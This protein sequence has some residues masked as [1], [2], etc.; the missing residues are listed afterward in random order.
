MF[1]EFYKNFYGTA[2]FWALYL[3]FQK[4]SQDPVSFKH[5]LPVTFNDSP[6]VEELCCSIDYRA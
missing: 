1:H 3:I 2:H 5:R 6:V 4:K